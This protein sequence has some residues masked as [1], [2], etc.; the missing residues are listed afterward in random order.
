M[1]T[2]K[3][4][5]TRASLNLY[6]VAGF[7]LLYIDYSLVSN[8]GSIESDS[9]KIITAIAAVVFAFFAIVIILHAFKGL[10]NINQEEDKMYEERKLEEK[11][12]EV[13]ETEDII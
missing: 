11:T 6:L 8:W 1:D 4:R 5:H 13:K 10:K 9:K 12:Q 2:K 3:K 7:Y